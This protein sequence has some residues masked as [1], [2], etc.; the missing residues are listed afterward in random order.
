MN[1]T[2]KQLVYKGGSRGRRAMSPQGCDF[3]YLVRIRPFGPFRP[4]R[5]HG[6]KEMGL[7]RPE[8]TSPEW[9]SLAV[10]GATTGAMP[11]VGPPARFRP[12]PL[13]EDGSVTA[14]WDDDH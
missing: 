12:P 1:D 8:W 2:L 3:F 7:S 6:M 9:P 13:P 14:T 5:S 10:G 11:R 4:L